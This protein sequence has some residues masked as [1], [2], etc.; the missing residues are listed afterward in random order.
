MLLASL[1]HQWKIDVFMRMLFIIVLNTTHPGTPNC[2]GESFATRPTKNGPS[3][4]FNKKK[5]T[6]LVLGNFTV[7]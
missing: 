5:T 3:R 7:M 1:P 4:F 6:I 2:E